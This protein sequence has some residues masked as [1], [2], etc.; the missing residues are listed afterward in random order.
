MSIK[1]VVDSYRRI[2]EGT[3]E[4]AEST[5]LSAKTRLV[6]FVAISGFA[7]LNGKKLWDSIAPGEF[8]GLAL[9]MLSLPWVLAAIF[10]VITH[11]II[12]EA[13]VKDDNYYL[14]KLA[15][16]DLHMESIE[17]GDA[18]PNEMSEIINDTHSDLE[19]AKKASDVWG[20]AARWLERITFIFVVLGF[21]WSMIGPFLLSCFAV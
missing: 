16:I 6:W 11:F 10:A 8:I 2:F 18:D 12:D 4:I 19:D 14:K 7:V 3:R 20:N 21:V 17:H 13:M 5:R 15:L 1:G 9:V